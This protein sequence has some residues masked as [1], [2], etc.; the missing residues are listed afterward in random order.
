MMPK[1]TQIPH[2]PPTKEELD[3]FVETH[4]NYMST[5]VNEWLLK[6]GD[7]LQDCDVVMRR[8]TMDRLVKELKQ[9]IH[10]L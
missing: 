1:I 6:S 4:V 7:L 10:Y 8:K 5:W 9:R 2:N 3:A